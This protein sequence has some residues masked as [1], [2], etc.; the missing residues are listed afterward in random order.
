M[1]LLRSSIRP[2]AFLAG[3]LAIVGRAPSLLAE[4]RLWAEEGTRYFPYAYGHNWLEALL[5]TQHGYYALWPNLA[6]TIAAKVVPLVAAPLVTTSCALLVQ[7]VPLAVILWGHSHL[8]PNLP[9]R[10]FG[11]S[12]Y[13][14]A[15][16]A[17]EV[18][19]NT[20]NSQFFFSVIA[21]LILN[22]DAGTQLTPRQ[23]TY[24]LLL[25]LAGLTGPVTCFLAPLF[26]WRA[27]T[28]RRRDEVVRAAILVLCAAI[29]AGS[30]LIS[31][32]RGELSAGPPAVGIPALAQIVWTQSVAL[33][34]LGRWIAMDSAT[35]LA[36]WASQ[37][38][39]LWLGFLMLI[40]AEAALFGY[41]AR[42]LSPAAR[43]YL[44]GAYGLVL[45]LSLLGALA[46]R[47]NDLVVPG[48]AGRYFY[49]PNVLLLLSVG[50]T[51]TW[52]R[53][54]LA[55]ARS[56]LSLGL[57]GAA[58]LAGMINYDWPAL[59]PATWPKWRDEVALYQQD[60]QHV[61]AIW[62]LGWTMT[63]PAP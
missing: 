60:H 63:L 44:L 4:P 61:L 35:A 59:A 24:N 50:Q 16:V 29:E 31:A 12:L 37:P 51:V 45:L 25:L 36:A 47:S 7:V 8:W 30:I 52:D 9:A 48:V 33:T 57:L 41:L 14:L 1:Q 11:V 19:L 18:W 43:R 53:A 2:L 5:Q 27:W 22:E 10:L 54:R 56:W 32:A 46:L 55:Q 40:V 21:V 3:V 26:V 28:E 20:I 23:W 62:P 34:L 42:T 6:A 38:L 49:A 15:P 13:L 58:L 17:G 39:Y